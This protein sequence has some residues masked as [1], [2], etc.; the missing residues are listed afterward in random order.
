VKTRSVVSERTLHGQLLPLG[1]WM[2][3]AGE[4]RRCEVVG[5]VGGVKEMVIGRLGDGHLLRKPSGT[6]LCPSLFHG[7]TRIVVETG[8][9]LSTVAAAEWPAFENAAVDCALF[10]TCLEGESRCQDKY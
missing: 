6:A 8:T 9:E 7:T 3:A 2:T 1:L 4:K 10:R 5:Y